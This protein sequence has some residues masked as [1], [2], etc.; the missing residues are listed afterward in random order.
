MF[1]D[2]GAG[3]SIDTV[4][5]TVKVITNYALLTAAANGD[6]AN[7]HFCH[8]SPQETLVSAVPIQQLMSWP[9]IAGVHRLVLYILG[10]KI[11][12]VRHF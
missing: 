8:Q 3:G 7:A 6:P 12:C 2:S 4:T 5:V 10:E 11:A 1:L 9:S